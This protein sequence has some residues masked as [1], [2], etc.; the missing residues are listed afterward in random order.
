MTTDAPV[1]DPP[2]SSAV[3]ATARPRVKGDLLRMAFWRRATHA[4]DLIAESATLE[5]LAHA[6]KA[7]TDFGALALALSN[8]DLTGPE[9]DLDPFATALARGAVEREQLALAAGGLLSARQVGQ[10]LGGITRQAVD[11]RRRAR[12]LLAVRVARD[13]RYPAV[14][15]DA[16]GSVPRCFPAIL[17]I[18]DELGMNGWATLDFLLAPDPA[19]DGFAPLEALRR[20]EVDRVCRLLE[21]ARSDSFG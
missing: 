10:V 3:V 12:Q 14:Q 4:I 9:C 11:K 8:T 1:V 21:A 20:E 17:Q 5:V 16:D 2:S 13:W 15:L 19:L 18:T 6:L 7:P